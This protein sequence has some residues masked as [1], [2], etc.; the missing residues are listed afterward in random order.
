[1]RLIVIS[2]E[3]DDERELPTLP[4][5]FAAGLAHY[6]LRKPAWD[7]DRLVTH[8]RA[9]PTEFHPR[10]VLH[11][12]HDLADEFNLG[13]FHFRDDATG[14]AGPPGPPRISFA[15]HSQSDAPGGRALPFLTSRACHDLNHLRAQLASPVRLL[16]SPVFPSISKPGHAPAFDHADLRA[17]L[18][19]PRRAEVIALGGIDAARLAE[20]RALGFDGA[21]L[22]GAVWLAPD[23]VATFTELLAHAR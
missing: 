7:R 16:F 10:I 5:L 1:M 18:A 15:S 17:V 4:R 23:P 9:I 22:L 3:G 20:C 11:A 19:P 8:L 14:R 13:G 12:H 21:A 6:H 2:P